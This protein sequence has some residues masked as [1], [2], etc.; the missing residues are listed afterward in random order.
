MEVM[1]PRHPIS[2]TCAL[3]V[4]LGVAGCRHEAE[5]NAEGEAKRGAQAEAEAEQLIKAPLPSTGSEA[6]DSII[7]GIE[8]DGS[9]VV[10]G[11][12]YDLK[13]LQGEVRR[14]V[15]DTGVKQ[16][17]VRVDR[18]AE[19]KSIIELLDMCR[20]HGFSNISLA[21]RREEAAGGTAP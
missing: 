5:P 13:A 6:T 3:L 17:I 10:D 7:I 1:K 14:I 2:A 21:V 15:E 4:A 18:D 16:L 8:A 20:K 11:T 9:Y 12:S 19:Y